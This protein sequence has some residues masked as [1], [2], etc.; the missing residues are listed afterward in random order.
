MFHLK[1]AYYYGTTKGHSWWRR[2]SGDGW[3]MRGAGEMWLDETGIHF[4]RYMTK[5]ILTIPLA[6]LKALETGRWHAGK[7]TGVEIV[8]VVW[9]HDGMVLVSGFSLAKHKDE[10]QK[11]LQILREQIPEK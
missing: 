8:K 7:W 11:Y 4:T 5:K 1:K 2:Y 9:Q 3:L 10:S 6:D